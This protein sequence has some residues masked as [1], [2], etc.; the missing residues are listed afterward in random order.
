MSI[1]LKYISIFS[2]VQIKSKKTK[3]HENIYFENPGELVSSLAS[4]SLPA[5]KFTDLT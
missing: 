1:I 5:R 3:Q 4:L 2:K